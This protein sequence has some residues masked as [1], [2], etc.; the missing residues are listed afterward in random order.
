MTVPGP[1]ALIAAQV[2]G[3]SPRPPREITPGGAPVA[4]EAPP[5]RID[6]EDRVDVRRTAPPAEPEARAAEASGPPRPTRPG[7]LIDISA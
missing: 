2:Y 3:T 5:P 7:T 4:V 1:T 6:V